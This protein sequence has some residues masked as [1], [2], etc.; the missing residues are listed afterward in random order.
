MAQHFDAEKI[1]HPTIQKL[2]QGIRNQRNFSF[3]MRFTRIDDNTYTCTRRV[4]VSAGYGDP[5]VF[6]VHITPG[7]FQ[8][9]V[10][11][12]YVVY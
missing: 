3:S 7:H 8:D 2:V 9:K 5:A 6:E 12:I 1:D 10:E 11:K 4:P